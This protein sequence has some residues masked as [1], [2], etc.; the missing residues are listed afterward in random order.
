[1]RSGRRLVLFQPVP[2]YIPP[3]AIT[4]TPVEDLMAAAAPWAGLIEATAETDAARR[5]DLV[6][7]TWRDAYA[8]RLAAADVELACRVIAGHADQVLAG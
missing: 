5:A 3:E 8:G 4:G 2:D 7:R 1:V 6:T